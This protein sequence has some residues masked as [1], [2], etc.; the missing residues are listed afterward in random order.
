MQA[1][2]FWSLSKLTGVQIINYTPV[3]VKN[4][5]NSEGTKYRRNKKSNKN[6]KNDISYQKIMK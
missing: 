3:E 4:Y 5:S 1:K 6:N 2:L